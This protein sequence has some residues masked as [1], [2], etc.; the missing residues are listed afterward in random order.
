MTAEP[1]FGLHQWALLAGI[2]AAVS[3]VIKFIDGRGNGTVKKDIA[4]MMNRMDALQKDFKSLN[5]LHMKTDD[6]G[7]PLVYF[8]RKEVEKLN[9]QLEE[10]I[11]LQRK[12]LG[13]MARLVTLHESR[14]QP[15]PAR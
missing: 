2:I 5:D 13:N 7:A 1:T 4:E 10:L 8:P 12:T 6:T 15:P 9:H 14:S 11:N 3:T